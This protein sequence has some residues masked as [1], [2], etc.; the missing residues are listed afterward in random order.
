MNDAKKTNHV[1]FDIER[2][3]GGEAVAFKP[4]HSLEVTKGF[5]HKCRS[6]ENMYFIED[7]KSSFF[8]DLHL[9]DLPNVI[10]GMWEKEKTFDNW[11][12]LSGLVR[13]I[14]KVSRHEWDG[15]NASGGH[16][17]KYNEL[18][19]RVNF[20]PDCKIGTIIKR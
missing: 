2:A 12:M 10:Y 11:D 3:L 9:D 20:F 4:P 19:L 15:L 8:F 1:K 17:A 13:V 6:K 14:K 16:I 18:S 5:L 7:L